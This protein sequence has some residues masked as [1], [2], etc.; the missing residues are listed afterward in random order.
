VSNHRPITVLDTTLREGE[1]T[2][3]VCFP[4]HVRAAIAESLETIGIDVI[5]AGHPAVTAEIRASVADLCQRGFNARI[6]AHARSLE[7]D[8]GLALDCGVDF[9]GIFY[10]VSDNRLN[11]HDRSL[12]QALDSISR[13]IDY[14]KA[15]CPD[16]VVR[17]TPEDA[18]R[19]PF[20]NVL[21]AAIAAAEAGADIISIADTTGY[22]VPGGDHSM[23]EHVSRLRDGLDARE[24]EPQI[25]VHC[26][27]DR[28]LALANALDGVRAGATVVDASVLGLG[29]RAGITDLAILLAVLADEVGPVRWRLAELPNLYR[30]VS[31]Y[32][33]VPVPVNQPVTGANAFTHCAGV[34]T[35]AAIADPLHYQS[36]DPALVGREARIALDHMSGLSSVRHALTDIEVDYDENTARLVLA[37][38]KRIGQSGHVVDLDELRLIVRFIDRSEAAAMPQPGGPSCVSVSCTR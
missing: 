24:L 32:A 13:V 21:A 27:N 36:L 28:G 1:Q 25:A 12:R 3:G 29:E 22:L 26:H 37:E 18:V 34:H 20:A 14:A 9:L 35:Q 30:L 4:G 16:V 6:A 19:S 11:H 31:R 8:V 33:S 23:Y 10:C 17:Y 15:R 7:S 2:P 5:E 38:V